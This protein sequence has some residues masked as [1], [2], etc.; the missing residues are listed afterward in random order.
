MHTRRRLVS[1]GVYVKGGSISESAPAREGSFDLH[2]RVTSLL[3]YQN[4]LAPLRRVAK[5]VRA[6]PQKATAAALKIG[7]TCWPSGFQRRG[8]GEG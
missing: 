4:Q 5:K 6:T 3:Y 1:V 8:E 7:Q 2:Q